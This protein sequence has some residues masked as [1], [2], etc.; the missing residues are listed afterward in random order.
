MKKTISII[1]MFLLLAS[2]LAVPIVLAEGVL[3]DEQIEEEQ[4]PSAFKYGWEKFKLNFVINQEI[5]AEKELQLARWKIA[6]ARIATQKGNIQRA[7]K[8]MQENEKM[9]YE[10]QERISKM[11][12]LTPGLDQA[13]KAQEQRIIGLKTSLEYA[14]LSEE[15]RIR[16]EEKF[17]RIKEVE[18]ILEQNRERIKEKKQEKLDEIGNNT[19]NIQD[20]LPQ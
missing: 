6:E 17:G 7:E 3:I 2:T 19:Q 15:Q 10:V 14:N 12:S 5:R 1:S 13:I 9:M 4:L 11:E 18:K 16:V 8:A 20:R